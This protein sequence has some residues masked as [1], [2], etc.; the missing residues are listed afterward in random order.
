MPYSPLI[1]YPVF[2]WWGPRYYSMK[3]AAKSR[4]G[5]PTNYIKSLAS[6]E[7]NT[8][9]VKLVLILLISEWAMS[10][11]SLFRSL[12]ASRCAK[13]ILHS[14][15]KACAYGSASDWKFGVRSWMNFQMF[16]VIVPL[17]VP[18]RCD[19]LRYTRGSG[20]IPRN[21]AQ[22][23]RYSCSSWPMPI[24]SICLRPDGSHGIHW[25]VR[26]VFAPSRSERMLRGRNCMWWSRTSSPFMSNSLKVLGRYWNVFGGN[27][28]TPSAWN[29]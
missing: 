10:R 15:S 13:I 18:Q 4:V 9:H 19:K 11:I 2:Y 23:S 8:D 7:S 20:E 14:V 21:F 29:E 26:W 3:L 5:R 22:Y 17:S 12:S 16:I 28:L 27:F 24:H 1:K 6:W 25:D